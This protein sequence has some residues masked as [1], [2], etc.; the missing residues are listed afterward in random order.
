MKSRLALLAFAAALGCVTI[1]SFSS[2][3]AQARRPQSLTALVA[4]LSLTR[5]TNGDGLADAV[6]AR[7]IVPSTP[8]MA[9]VEVA[10]NL[11]ARIGYETTALTLPLVLRDREVAQPASIVVPI[12]VGRSNQFIQRLVGSK[13]L[14]I[15]TLHPG[16]GLIAADVAR[17]AGRDRV[18]SAVY[19]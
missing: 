6:A 14:D 1:P 9:D 7:V 4:P 17:A 12:L 2:L 11:A 13:T 10:T 5:D 18:L 19:N 15:T 8:A 3:D 16:Q